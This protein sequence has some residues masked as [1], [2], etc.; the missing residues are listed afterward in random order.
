MG[1]SISVNVQGGVLGQTC[2]WG[3]VCGAK[4]GWRRFAARH[5]AVDDAD[6]VLPDRHSRARNAVSSDDPAATADTRLHRPT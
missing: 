2:R 4:D 5:G 6:G 1:E 3:A